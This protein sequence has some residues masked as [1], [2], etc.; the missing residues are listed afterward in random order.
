MTL[1]AFRDK[2]GDV[3]QKGDLTLLCPLLDDPTDKVPLAFY[4]GVVV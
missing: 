3:P 4:Q 1:E 2:F